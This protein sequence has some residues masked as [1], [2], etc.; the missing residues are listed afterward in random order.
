M[1]ISPISFGSLMVFRLKQKNTSIPQLMQVSFDNN[2]NLQKY[3]LQTTF[4]YNEKIDGTV[5][6]AALNFAKGLD[7]KY[8]KELK[9]N[10]NKVFLTQVE[11]YVNP[12][13]TETRYFLTSG[14][15]SE[16]KIHQALC[17]SG[18]YYCQKFRKAF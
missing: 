17:N 16:Q 4:Y 9:A 13:D 18:L 1:R 10:P 3:S 12:R 15:K 5:H 6:N 14:D 2:P 11:F 8:E 7:K